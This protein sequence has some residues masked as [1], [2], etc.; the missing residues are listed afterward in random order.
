MHRRPCDIIARRNFKCTIHTSLVFLKL[1]D[2]VLFSVGGE[3]VNDS[4]Q[5]QQHFF[6]LFPQHHSRP[7]NEF[8]FFDSSSFYIGSFLDCR[9]HPVIF[10]FDVSCGDN[11]KKKTR[12]QC[13][14]K[15][16]VYTDDSR[17]NSRLILTTVYFPYTRHVYTLKIRNCIDSR[18]IGAI[19]FRGYPWREWLYLLL[20]IYKDL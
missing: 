10:F 3:W 16:T 1:I 14:R 2:F 11:K 4:K 19:T 20:Y 9:F 17:P 6:S 15:T 18:P 5:Q 7:I 12:R 13:P 8:D